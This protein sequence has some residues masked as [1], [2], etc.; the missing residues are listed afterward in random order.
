MQAI[1]DLIANFLAYSG[2]T[3]S[4]TPI[5]DQPHRLK[6]RTTETKPYRD[7]NTNTKS[8]P[9]SNPT[10]P[11]NPTKPWLLTVCGVADPEWDNTVIF[12]THYY[13][14]CSVSDFRE[15]T[16]SRR[17]LCVILSCKHVTKL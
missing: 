8:N 14:T 3:D 10:Y 5:A 15:T 11:T 2:K 13:D 6:I 1:G 9:N 17:K 4:V 12:T 16:G 7:P